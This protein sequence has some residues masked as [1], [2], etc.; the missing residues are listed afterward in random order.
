[1][2]LRFT[3]GFH[4]IFICRGNVERLRNLEITGLS[5]RAGVYS[6]RVKQLLISRF[7]VQFPGGSPL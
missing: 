1:M 7:G 4:S 6:D 2:N 5:G 3:C